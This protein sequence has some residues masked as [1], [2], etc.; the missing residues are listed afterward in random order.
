ME[1]RV[2]AILRAMR[3]DLPMPRRMSLPLAEMVAR[4]RSM[5]AAKGA[6]MGPSRRMASERRARASIRTRSEGVVGGGG[7]VIV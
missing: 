7:W 1:R 2:A 5:A 4:M 3:P 6:A